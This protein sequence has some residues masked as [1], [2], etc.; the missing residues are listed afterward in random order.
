MRKWQKTQTVIIHFIYVFREE[1]YVYFRETQ[2]KNVLGNV[3]NGLDAS[4]DVHAHEKVTSAKPRASEL[5]S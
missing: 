5:F 2:A 4:E 3:I 1:Q